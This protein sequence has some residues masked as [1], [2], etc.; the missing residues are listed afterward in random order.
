MRVVI[1]SFALLEKEKS[2]N[3]ARAT[4]NFG[5][6]ITENIKGGHGGKEQGGG[7]VKRALLLYS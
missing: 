3:F 6:K 1:K 7:G 2:R 5:V 4:G